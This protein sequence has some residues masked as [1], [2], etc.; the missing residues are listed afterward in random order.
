VLATIDMRKTSV[1]IT[2]CTYNDKRYLGDFLDSLRKQPVWP[3]EL[4]IRDDSSSDSTIELL[5]K[6]K[7]SAPFNVNII[8]NK[9]L[10]KPG[11]FLWIDTPNITSEGYRLYVAN[12]L[13]LDPPRHLALFTLWP[14]YNTL[15]IAGFAETKAQPYRPLC[16][17]SFGC[18]P[19]DSLPNK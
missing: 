4:F 2:L 11:G 6:L 16:N 14:M 9:E 8:L 7:P 18:E 13:R 12:W 10:L 15:N 5:H 17:D 3:H 19:H 1:S